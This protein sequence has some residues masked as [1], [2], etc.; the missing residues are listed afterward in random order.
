MKWF[1]HI[2]M[3]ERIE[4]IVTCDRERKTEGRIWDEGDN[5]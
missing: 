5:G 1:A 3:R 4:E 2:T